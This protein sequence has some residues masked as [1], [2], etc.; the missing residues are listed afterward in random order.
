VPFVRSWFADF[1]PLAGNGPH[2]QS[3]GTQF[4]IHFAVAVDCL[5]PFPSPRTGTYRH[6]L[7]AVEWS[8]QIT[9]ITF[10]IRDDVGQDIFAEVMKL[11]T[12][13]HVHP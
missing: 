9:C 6:E 10:P 4:C 13:Y 8:V 1:E 7:A 11:L 12:Q 3:R 2:V 5:L